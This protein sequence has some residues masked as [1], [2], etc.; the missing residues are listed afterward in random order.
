MKKLIILGI[1][2]GLSI[3]AAIA[4]PSFSPAGWTSCKDTCATYHVCPAGYGQVAAYRD[5]CLVVDNGMPLCQERRWNL[6]HCLPNSQNM[7]VGNR[8]DMTELEP[9]SCTSTHDGCY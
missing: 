7:G 9:G 2:L 4:R 1:T 3:G 5:P 8:F 6:Y